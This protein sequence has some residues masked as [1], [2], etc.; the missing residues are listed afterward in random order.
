MINY[1]IEVTICWLLFYGCYVSFLHK[2]TFFRLNRFYLIGT[3]I[4][5]LIIP[6]LEIAPGS[7]LVLQLQKTILLDEIT[8][9]ANAINSTPSPISEVIG[10]W[11]W[12]LIVT[13]LYMSIALLLALSFLKGLLQIYRLIRQ[14]RLVPKSNY[15][16]IETTK[17][18]APFSFFHYLFLNKESG[19]STTEQHQVIT[20]ELAHIKGHH[21]L[22]V[23]LMELM[24]V[25]LWFHPLIFLY[26]RSIKENHE[27]LADNAVLE[28]S[29]K[30]QYGRLL[31]EQAIPGLRL[32]N[33]FNY[34]LLKKRIK[35]MSTHKSKSTDLLKYSICIPLFMFAIVLFSCKKDVVEQSSEDVIAKNFV[36]EVSSELARKGPTFPGSV[37]ENKSSRVIFDHLE[38]LKEGATPEMKE[39]ISK[40]I[41]KLEANLIT[42]PSA[43]DENGYY[44][45]VDE[46]PRYP[47]CESGSMTP[48]ERRTCS[49]KLMLNYIYNNITYPEAAKTAGIEGMVIIQFYLNEQ[50]E[51]SSPKVVRSIGGG[52]DEEAL[53]V[54]NEMPD[55]IPGKL[56]GQT[57]KF[58]YTLPVKFKLQ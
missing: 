17:P 31:L 53:R 48:L 54:V 5:G 2:E 1:M 11:D 16:R 27:F 49:K 19:L 56:D 20:H 24:T 25:F 51:I 40:Q 6:L 45:L 39:K 44:G 43:P 14:G 3:F 36:K 58:K 42:K 12:S 41:E 50:G 10:G 9:T 34:S 15:T 28:F 46:S 13:I 4:G 22:D 8:I 55:W 47:G 37:N 30:K 21:S 7:D 23:L 18:H 26:K 52:C 57:V 38:K 32:A 33:N 35:M 29:S